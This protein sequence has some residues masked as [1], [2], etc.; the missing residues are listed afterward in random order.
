MGFLMP[1]APSIPLPPPPAPP[2]AAAAPP[3]LADPSLAATSDARA[4]AGKAGAAAST[5]T[6]EGGA[7]GLGAPP[8]AL[9]S[10]L[11]QA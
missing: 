2:P 9:H 10:L 11:G 3:T 5:I 7:Q 8:V 1:S 4:R 6:N